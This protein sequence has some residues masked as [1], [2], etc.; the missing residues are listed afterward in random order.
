VAGPIDSHPLRDDPVSGGARSRI[1]LG[2]RTLLA[3]SDGFIRIPPDFLGSPRQPTA[4]YD[5]LAARYGEARLPL[6]CFVWPGDQNVLIDA[7]LGPVDYAGRGVM[8]GGRLIERLRDDGFAPSDIDM[9]CLSHL[10]ADHTGWIADDNGE[11]VFPRA[12]V[13]IGESDW[14]HFVVEGGD[15]VLDERLAHALRLLADRGRVELLDGERSVVPGLAR[16]AAPGHTPGHSIYLAHDGADRVML[17]GDA[18][19]CPH[20]LTND[21]WAAMSDVDPKLAAQTR[22]RFVRD[23]AAGGGR[24]MGCHFPE[25][26]AGRAWPSRR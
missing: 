3:V 24:A 1:V 16:L 15:P 18:M 19:Y 21:E 13:L 10:H 9:V 17:L 6:G 25:L 5:A 23:L 4:A 2:N 11:P 22:A 8:V 12:R 7:G 20:Q 14:N 26:I